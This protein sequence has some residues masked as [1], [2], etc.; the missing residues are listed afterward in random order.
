MVIIDRYYYDMADGCFIWSFVY[1]NK[2]VK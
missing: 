1:L 2:V